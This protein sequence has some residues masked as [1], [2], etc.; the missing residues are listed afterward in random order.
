MA[1]PIEGSTG[2]DALEVDCGT[3]AVRGVG[4]P[5]CVVS[6][7]LGPPAEVLTV[8]RDQVRAL[9]VLAGSGLVPPLRHRTARQA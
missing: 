2:D 5:D 6:F 1:R 4:C 3:C 7:L 9:R 8:D